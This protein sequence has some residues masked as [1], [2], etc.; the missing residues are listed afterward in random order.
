MLRKEKNKATKPMK[1]KLAFRK[2]ICR[3]EKVAN[4]IFVN[5]FPKCKRNPPR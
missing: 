1:K 2:L 5:V 3:E 4:Y